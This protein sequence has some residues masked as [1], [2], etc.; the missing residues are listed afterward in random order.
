MNTKHLYTSLGSGVT[1]GSVTDNTII[2]SS[3]IEIYFDNTDCY[4]D[5]TSQEGHT[6]Y[7]TVGGN[8]TGTNVCVVV[9]NL[10]DFVPYDDTEVQT[11]LSLLDT[12]ISTL[13]DTVSNH[14]GVITAH[15]TELI[16]LQL[17]KQDVLT[18]G[19]NITIVDNVISATG[20]DAQE[21]YTSSENVIGAYLNKPLYRKVWTL[22]N[23]YSF[24]SYSWKDITEIKIENVKSITRFEMIGYA[25]NVYANYS[26]SVNTE[27][28]ATNGLHVLNMRNVS[29]NISPGS[30]IIL[31]YTKT[32]D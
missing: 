11:H 10:T 16:N 12:D 2:D 21:I 32:T 6:V 14:T 29:I 1:Q 28:L 22:D 3:V 30:Q 17:H 15:G 26:F 24:A 9:N 25:N 7:F 4:I 19:D 8:A 18:P 13:N 27:N 5:G 20:G 23:T 31:E